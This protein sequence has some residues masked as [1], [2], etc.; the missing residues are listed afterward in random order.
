MAISQNFS[1]VSPS[2]T[3]NFARSKTL[4]PRITFTR[5]T[6]ATRL[7]D[8]GLVEVVSA[9]TP[10]FN[11][12]FNTTTQSINSLG[13]LIEEG[14]T[15]YI[16]NNTMQGV[17]VGTP[18]TPPTGWNQ[19]N[20]SGLTW[21]IVGTGTDFG[22]NYVDMRLSG[23]A[24]AS[25][26]P[27]FTFTGNSDI[28]ASNGQTWTTS[29]FIKLVS[30]STNGITQIVLSHDERSNIFLT[31]VPSSNFLSSINSSTSNIF[32]SCRYSFSATN[33]NASTTFLYPYLLITPT[34]GSIVDITLRV[35]MPQTELGSFLTS[36]IPTSGS[37][38]SR[39]PDNVTMTGTNFSSWY[40]QREGSINVNFRGKL[41]DTSSF[42]RVYSINA[43]TPGVEETTL[44]YNVGYNPDR[45]GYLVYDNS[46]AIQDTTGTA[47]GFVTPSSSAVKTAMGYLS[48]SYV[49]GF[50]GQ[51]PITGS[52]SGVPTPNVLDIGR[53]GAGSFLNGTISQLSYY[54]KRVTNNQ[55]QTLTL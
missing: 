28:P 25:N 52:V 2:L 11:H 41:Q 10:R 20:R 37:T 27:T 14:R 26:S 4:D 55:L 21:S 19:V 31:S 38:V 44:V 49:Y 48:G 18:G 33:T 40:N 1:A 22:I 32:S 12:S 17:V 39:T 36:I 51:T 3:L 8:R 47:G 5:T 24:N 6:A 16:L 13:L 34:N 9:N 42:D 29:C 45:I 30:G 54:P 46:V 43:G 53:V 50:N 23:T 35:G 15:N 7:N